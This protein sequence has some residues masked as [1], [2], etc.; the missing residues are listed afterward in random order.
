MFDNSSIVGKFQLHDVKLINYIKYNG[1]FCDE[2][3]D[4]QLC[5]LVTCLQD[6]KDSFKLIV[7]VYYKVSPMLKFSLFH[8]N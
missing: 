4:R 6:A 5:W 7:V 8:R 3:R 2:G 1:T